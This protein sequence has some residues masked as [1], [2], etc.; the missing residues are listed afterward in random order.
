[1]TPQVL[2]L[3]PSSLTPGVRAVTDSRPIMGPGHLTDHLYIRRLSN[4]TPRVA[5]RMQ[6]SR[7]PP[8]GLIPSAGEGLV[9]I[10]HR[11]WT[12]KVD[13]G[14]SQYSQ[15]QMSGPR[16]Q[17]MQDMHGTYVTRVQFDD[18][19]ECS[20]CRDVFTDMGTNIETWSNG[21]RDPTTA[22]TRQCD[23]VSFFLWGLTMVK[24]PC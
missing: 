1:M 9:S 8:T 23:T 10:L 14:N 22:P 17:Q 21:M 13:N 3:S 7:T 2:L 4:F 24:W 6:P 18:N 11:D 20:T 19:R 5:R 16:E 15:G 12:D